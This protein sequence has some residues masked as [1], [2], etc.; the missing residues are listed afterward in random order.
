MWD[1]RGSGE[2]RGGRPA[3][4]DSLRAVEEIRVEPI[5]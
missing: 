4:D 3:D 5:E 2:R 1:A